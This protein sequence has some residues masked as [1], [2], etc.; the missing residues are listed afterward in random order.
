MKIIEGEES[1]SAQSS[2]SNEFQPNDLKS[3]LRSDLP[4]FNPLAPGFGPKTLKKFTLGGGGFAFSA[5]EH[6][7]NL[8]KPEEKVSD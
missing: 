6:E 4:K 7:S 3:F 8:Y 2:C 5:T 1:S